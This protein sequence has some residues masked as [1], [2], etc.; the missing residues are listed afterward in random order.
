MQVRWRVSPMRGR[1]C[2]STHHL[3]AGAVSGIARTSPQPERIAGFTATEERYRHTLLRSIQMPETR[4]R[5]ES[6]HAVAITSEGG[7]R[8]RGLPLP[9]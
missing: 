8:G 3:G 1:G 4:I 5:E 2:R 6:P 9:A 7:D